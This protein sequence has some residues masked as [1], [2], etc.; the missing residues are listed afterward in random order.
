M[1]IGA[2]TLLGVA[3][4]KHVAASPTG[5]SLVITH[6]G[7]NVIVDSAR[8]VERGSLTFGDLHCQV[9]GQAGSR[10]ERIGSQ[11]F[12]SFAVAKFYR[13]EMRRINAQRQPLMADYVVHYLE[14]QLRLLRFRSL[15]I[16]HFVSVL[17]LVSL[18]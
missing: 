3:G 12:F 16:V 18:L 14:M 10:Y 15:G 5:A 1:K 6:G 8:L 4:V 2:V 9:C 13:F 7:E 17:R 11:K